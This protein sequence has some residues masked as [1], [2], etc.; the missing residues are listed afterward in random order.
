[1]CPFKNKEQKLECNGGENCCVYKVL[2]TRPGCDQESHKNR[3]IAN[4]NGEHLKHWKK[5]KKKENGRTDLG[6]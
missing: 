6:V 2:D 1:M 4:D 3:S 5:E